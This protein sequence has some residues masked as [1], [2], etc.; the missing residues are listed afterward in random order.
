MSSVSQLGRL[1]YKILA[2]DD[3]STDENGKH[4]NKFDASQYMNSQ[5]D[6]SCKPPDTALSE[7]EPPQ[8]SVAERSPARKSNSIHTAKVSESKHVSGLAP[9]S[10]LKIWS[11]EVL[12]SLFGP[13]YQRVS[14]DASRSSPKKHEANSST[15][16]DSPNLQSHVKQ[17]PFER[18]KVRPASSDSQISEG[19]ECSLGQNSTENR[20]EKSQPSHH[21]KPVQSM[22]HSLDE[23][24]TKNPINGALPQVPA[25]ALQNK[26]HG[27][28]KNSETP[29]KTKVVDRKNGQIMAGH[30]EGPYLEAYSMHGNGGFTRAKSENDLRSLSQGKDSKDE[31]P[32]DPESPDGI[33]SDCKELELMSGREVAQT[34]YLKIIFAGRTLAEQIDMIEAVWGFHFER[35]T[36]PPKQRLESRSVESRWRIFQNFLSR[37]SQKDWSKILLANS[38][39]IGKEDQHLLA[40]EALDLTQANKCKKGKAV[41]T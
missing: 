34:P 26:N 36:S 4:D 38:L 20:D 17:R 16:D 8:T 39:D 30:Q 6:F 10:P 33:D 35:K 9:K 18:M 23:P 2:E 32:P 21:P 25:P 41:D 27:E 37:R 24:I 3:R 15:K 11:A 28:D 14:G 40:I 13:D 7:S 19:A 31:A 12:H 22:G 29:W 1:T 5:F